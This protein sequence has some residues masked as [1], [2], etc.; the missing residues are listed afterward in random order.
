[1]LTIKENLSKNFINAIGWS[2]NQKLLLI[3][4]DDWGAVRMPSR[5]VYEKLIS[6]MIRVDELHFD[7]YDS[8][9]SECDLASLYEVLKSNNDKNGKNP[10]ITAFSVVANPNFEQIKASEK[11]NY[12]YETI[13][14]TYQRNAH[15][16]NTPELIKQGIAENLFIPQYHGRE[17]I[18]VKRWMEAI[19]SNSKKERIAFNNNAIISSECK[20]CDNPYKKNYFTGFDYDSIEEFSSLEQIHQEGLELFKNIFGFHSISFVAQGSVWGDH[21]LKTLHKHGVQLVIGQQ[22]HPNMKGGYTVINK[23]WG[24]KNKLGQIYWRRNCKFEPSRNQNFDWVGKCLKEIEIAF[25]WGKPAVISSHRENFIGSIFESNRTQ[26][27][28]KL[29]RLLKSVLKKWP[30][31]RFIS[32]AELAKIMLNNNS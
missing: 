9:E 27:L 13:L 17:H 6:K 21:I 28:E 24:D 15:T 26:S 22:S 12:E 31:V 23:K 7:K 5:D 14:E 20:L 3:E 18:H 2:T 30:D 25:R 10:V 32:T 4:S 29:D 8:V 19:N 1:M 11:N 16:H